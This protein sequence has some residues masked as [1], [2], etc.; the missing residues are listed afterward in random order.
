MQPI[1]S[2]SK[3]DK[4]RERNR[5]RR[6]RYLARKGRFRVISGVAGFSLVTI[7]TN[8]PRP[9]A[10]LIDVDLEDIAVALWLRQREAFVDIGGQRF[11]TPA[12]N[13]EQRALLRLADSELDK[14]VVVVGGG[15][16]LDAI[17]RATAPQ[18][19]R[20]AAE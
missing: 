17:D 14:L 19:I 1:S 18:P 20:A 8:P 6:L 11:R 13:R 16:L 2:P 9:I 10:G 3:L 4:R 5:L 15:R 7:G 12:M